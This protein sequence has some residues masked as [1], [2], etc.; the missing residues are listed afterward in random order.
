MA[1]TISSFSDKR[2]R[3]R[4]NKYYYIFI[5][6]LLLSGNMIGQTVIKG[7]VVDEKT[8]EPLVGASV[9]L[10]STTQGSLT[11]IDGSFSL[12]VSGQLPVTIRVALVGFK[13]QELDVYENNGPIIIPLTED[14]NYLNE[15]I[16]VGYGTQKRKEL[17]GAIS[18]VSK[19][20]LSQLST[21]F[22]GLLG[23]AVSGLNVSQNSGQPGTT[24]NIRIR[25]GN[26]INGGNEPLYVIDGVII[27]NDNS[28]A[29]IG[30]SRAAGALNPLAALN[31]GDIESIEVLKDVSAS[32][33]YGSRGANGVIIITT[34]SGR[35]G[36]TNIEYQYSIG[37]QQAR[38][39]LDLMNA[40]EWGELYLEIASAENISET[41][42]TA[43]KVA[44]LGEGTNWQD[45]ALR[46]AT[47][48]N[49]QLS[50]SGGDDKTR[51]LLSGNYSDQDGILLNTGFKRY[52][53]RFNFERDLFSNLTVGLNVTA[54]KMD[55]SGLSSYNGL[56]VN[57]VSNSLDYVLRIPQV[58]SIYN[59]DGSYNYN[60]LF[61]KGD[62]RFGDRTV[63]AI[64]DL[65]NTTSQTKNNTLIG[66]FFAKYT[67]IPSL[68]AK[69]SA[70]TNLSNTTLNFFAPSSAAAGFLAKGYGSIGN[71]RFDSWQ[72]EYTL[73][74]TKKLNKDHYV[75]I[76]A[77]Y[78][79]QT[80]DIEYSIAS[81][82][83]FAN[84][85]LSY[86][87]L[88]GGATL[89]SPSS[90]GSESILNSVLGRVNYSFLGRYNLTG[91]F[92]ADG[93][94]RFAKNHKWGYFPSIG[95]SWN[96]SEEPFLKN[97]KVINDLKLRGSFG[98]VGNQ[99][100]GD[101]RY[102]AT[103]ATKV[104]SF[105]NQLV[106]AYG[107]ANAENPDLKWEETSQYN[108]GFDLN[109]LNRR[110][111]I[112]ADVYYKKTSDLLLDVP[113]EITTGFSTMLMNVGNVTNKGVEFAL[114]GSIIDQK[115]L[116]WNLSANIAK[117]VNEVTNIGNLD[118]FLS[119]NTIIKKGESLGSFYGVAFDGIVQT[120]TDISKV[121]APSWK[122]NVEPGD[123]KYVDQNNDGKV[124]QDEDRVVLGSIQ[125]DFTYG[126]ST[127][128]RYKSL[129]LFA[130]FQG[131][132]GNQLYNQ[133]RQELESPSTSYNV[134]ATLRDRWTPQ[135]PSNTIAK[136]S[137][138]SATWLDS[139]YIEDASFLRLKNITLSYVLPVKI[140]KAPQTKFRIFAT[141]QNLLT[142]TKYKG[143]DPEVSSGIDSG[144]YPTAKTISFGVNISY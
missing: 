136:A 93:S 26:S 107:R 51:F 134:L 16:V 77:G 88:Q 29:N 103:Y 142:F 34:K 22:D 116:Q 65:V 126:F 37:W 28:S 90:G 138:T 48:Q 66:N 50:I 62:L 39:K 71:K 95:L 104:Y 127:T 12:P 7:T 44:Q 89:L 11:D 118:Y 109:L 85:Q 82:S 111:G 110:L 144:A 36:K 80:T 105:N 55:Q 115:D 46:T 40:R 67:I 135:N 41:G 92:R 54:S 114:T 117:N 1:K 56:Y 14:L 141:G 20:A 24:S 87:N 15:V 130:A 33:I 25:G 6:F 73:N 121:P 133:L 13:S 140:T 42:L 96:V 69:V 86:H 101:Y 63:N 43:E 125:P 123:V 74:Y 100:I 124:T 30:I 47:T 128:L 91:T 120:G 119:G 38:K 60:N 75:D 64:S 19:D 8:G 21:S 76:L 99:E 113:V 106:T 45:A 129:S 17:T 57:G 58:V 61:E 83:N 84:E 32:A 131:S 68:V 2:D 23:G 49:H 122:T 137:V 79:T 9:A 98:V 112:T 102:E 52:S 4:V 10:V 18:S 108:L 72:Y 59:Q 5:F 81:A 94:S 97:N 78:T 35:K 31:P 139:R 27:Y 132:K 70:G 53:G 143:Y 3:Y